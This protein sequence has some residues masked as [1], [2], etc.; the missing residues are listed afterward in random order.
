L[1]READV[2]AF[3]RTHEPQILD[4]E[5]LAGDVDVEREKRQRA[6]KNAAAI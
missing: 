4:G 3:D 1:A 5:E 6:R 2:C